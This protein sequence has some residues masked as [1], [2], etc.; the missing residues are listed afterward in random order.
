MRSM[1]DLYKLVVDSLVSAV[2]RSAPHELINRS[3]SDCRI[4]TDEEEYQFHRDDGYFEIEDYDE[5]DDY[6][7]VNGS[8]S[9]DNGLSIIA[10][11]SNRANASNSNQTKGDASKS[12]N[13]D[14]SNSICRQIITKPNEG[15]SVTSLTGNNSAYDRKQSSNNNHNNNNNNKHIENEDDNNNKKNSDDNKITYYNY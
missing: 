11:T 7:N 14:K 6:E 2:H 5:L 4:V 3:M 15:S 9:D 8:F 10:T 13:N 12:C 1:K